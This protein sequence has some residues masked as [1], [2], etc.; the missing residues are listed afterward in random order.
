M[1][2][3]F[4][5]GRTEFPVSPIFCGND[6]W[7]GTKGLGNPIFQKQPHSFCALDDAIKADSSEQ[8]SFAAQRFRHR[9]R[10][11]FICNKKLRAGGGRALFS[12]SGKKRASGLFLVLIF[13]GRCQTA[14]RAAKWSY[15]LKQ[16]PHHYVGKKRLSCGTGRFNS[17]L[18]QR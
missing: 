17:E 11:A 16:P 5:G 3:M 1:V 18:S 6:R 4:R 2:A 8:D 15:K 14:S 9:P 13:T 7:L 12:Q 10:P